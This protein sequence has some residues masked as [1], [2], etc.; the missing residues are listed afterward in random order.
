MSKALVLTVMTGPQIGK[1]HTVTERTAKIGSASSN[2]IVLADRAVEPWH[3]EITQMLDRWFITPRSTRGILLNGMPINGRSRLNPGDR[4]T[5]G[6]VMYS[7]AVHEVAEP[8]IGMA[9]AVGSAVPR[10]GE[11]LIRRGLMTGDQVTK[12]VGRQSELE[13][14][15]SRVMFGQLAY[16]MG[17]VNRSQLNAALAEQRTDFDEHFRD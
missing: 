10:I 16:E 14:N 11:Y 4:L 1:S 13:R 8:E 12:T 7:I 6:S 2:E 17:Y 9:R 5:I 15:G 3:A